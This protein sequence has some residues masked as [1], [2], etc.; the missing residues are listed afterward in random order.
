MKGFLSGIDRVNK[1]V[2]VG[3]SY[4]ILAM[5]FMTLYEVI[6]RFVFNAPTVWAHK[7]TS[8]TFGFY[9][10]MAGGYVLL[11]KAHIR[12]DVLWSRLSPRK[13]AIVD[14]LTFTIAF[15][16]IG[17]LLYRIGIF[18][19]QSTQILERSY[20]PFS[21]YVWP[22]KSVMILGGS[23]LLLQLIAKYIR[24]LHLAITGADYA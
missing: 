10:I 24:D 3:M 6:A 8:Q 2:G 7:I 19:W 21:I 20:P 22:L 17:V 15:L 12:V 16:F 5:I 23:L 1:W 11:L 18:A 9:L 4:I 13:R 14:L